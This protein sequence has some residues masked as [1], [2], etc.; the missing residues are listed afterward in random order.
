[1]AV[2]FLEFE[3]DNG[4]AIMIKRILVL[5]FGIFSYLLG[6]SALV[7]WILSMMGVM[8]FQSQALD[9][10]SLVVV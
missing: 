7:G 3:P 6:V 1:M 5:L 8:P 9:G 2:T 10:S 4:N